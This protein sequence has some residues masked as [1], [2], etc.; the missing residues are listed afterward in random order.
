M[1][2]KRFKYAF[3][4]KKEAEGGLAS[5]TYA[6]LSLGIFL[7]SAVSA[8]ITRGNNGILFGA[9][10]LAAMLFA[11]CGFVTGLVSFSEK[12]RKHRGS[13]I[14]SLISGI[15]AVIWLSLYLIG[16]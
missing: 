16:I 15:L 1:G 14:G 12:D 13:V 3:A 5:L 11:L 6:G 9:L 10:G 2:R 4:G 7:V 8:F